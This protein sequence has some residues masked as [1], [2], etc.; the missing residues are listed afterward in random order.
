MP[1]IP[2][3][4][5]HKWLGLITVSL[6]MFLGALDLSVNVALPAITESFGS[7]MSTVQWLSLIHI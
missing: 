4:A 6:G 5:H 1:K 2:F 7:E 3:A